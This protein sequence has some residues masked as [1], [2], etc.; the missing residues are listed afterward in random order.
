MVSTRFCARCGRRVESQSSLLK[1][2]CTDCYLEV[3]GFAELPRSIN[4]TLCSGCGAYRAGGRW[5]PSPGGIGESIQAAV[6]AALLSSVSPTSEVSSITLEE[7]DI[8]MESSHRGSIMARFSVTLRNGSRV[9]RE[10]RTLLKVSYGLCPQCTRR[11]GKVYEA[12]IQVRSEGGRLSHRQWMEVERFISTLPRRL[13]ESI[14]EV[15]EL[16]EGVDLKITDQGAARIIAAKLRDRFAAKV[17]ETHKVIGRRRDGKVK[18]RITYSVR[19]PSIVE[20][21]KLIYRGDLVTVERISDNRVYLRNARG[22]VMVVKGDELWR[23]DLFERIDNA[24]LEEYMVTAVTGTTIHLMKM[25]TYETIEIPKTW[26][27]PHSDLEPG[28]LVKVHRSGNKL[29]VL[30]RGK[31]EPGR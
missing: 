30:E 8:S 11:A 1:G 25:D 23:E 13:A 22:K 9:E 7:L 19:L 5:L 16:R 15:E 17:V 4:V 3:Y 6:E 18:V 12:I 20:G 2:L 28:V 26:L 21:E 29:Y 31:Y 24:S 14:G 10:I 27:I